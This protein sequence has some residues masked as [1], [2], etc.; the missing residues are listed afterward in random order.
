MAQLRR[1]AL[2]SEMWGGSVSINVEREQ[3]PQDSKEGFC[4]LAVNQLYSSNSGV[5]LFP[6]WSANID[7]PSFLRSSL[8]QT[9]SSNASCGCPRSSSSVSHPCS[10]FLATAPDCVPDSLSLSPTWLIISRFPMLSGAVLIFL[11]L[12]CTF[13]IR[14]PFGTGSNHGKLGPYS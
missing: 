5:L 8:P 10:E 2:S 1:S 7:P 11:R 13:D 14:R 4:S 12:L 6:W 9:L 3:P